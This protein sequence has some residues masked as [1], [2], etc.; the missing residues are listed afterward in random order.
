[1]SRPVQRMPGYRPDELIGRHFSA[2]APP[3]PPGAVA[4]ELRAMPSAPAPRSRRTR[5]AGPQRTAG[6]VPVESRRPAWSQ[7]GDFVGA[8]G[9][10]RDVSER[11]A[12]SATCGARPASSRPV[13]E[14]PH[15]ARELH[16]SVTQAL[17]SMTLVS[18][19]IEMLLSRDPYAV[20]GPARPAARPAARGARR[21]AGAD[22]RAAAGQPRGGR[23][24][25]ALRTHSAALRAAS[26]CRSSSR[27]T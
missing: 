12:S 20:P 26:A 17:F 27:A 2:I 24:V 16:D 13:E 5:P 8:H 6:D 18:R 3:R 14:R 22:L 25:P 21:D 9:A 7:D 10:A 19:S 1:M 15:L 23:A 11:T 4:A